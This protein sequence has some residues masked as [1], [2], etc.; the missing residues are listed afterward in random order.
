MAASPHRWAPVQAV[1]MTGRPRTGDNLAESLHPDSPAVG[2]A[3]VAQAQDRGGVAMAGQ[4]RG[5]VAVL[6]AVADE[7]LA[8]SGPAACDVGGDPPG[9]GVPGL[10]VGCLKASWP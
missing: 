6:A 7:G 4:E 10:L 1:Q 5:D 2:G 3:L 8:E 9:D